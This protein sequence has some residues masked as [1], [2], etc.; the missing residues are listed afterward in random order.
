VSP[1]ALTL[2]AQA[3]DGSPGYVVAAV[4]AATLVLLVYLAIIAF[5]VRGAAERLDALERR[6]AAPDEAPA[7]PAREHEAA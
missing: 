1:T 2:L 5:R 7:T 6:T 4:I 3:D